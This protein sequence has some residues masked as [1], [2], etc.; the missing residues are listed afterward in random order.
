MANQ[1]I[2]NY[3]GQFFLNNPIIGWSIDSIEEVREVVGEDVYD[4][5]IEDFKRDVYD[6]GIGQILFESGIKFDLGGQTEKSRIIT[7]DNPQGIFDF[8]LAS[9]GLFRVQEFFS[10]DLFKEKRHLFFEYDLPLGVVPVQMINERVVGGEKKYVFTDS[11]G[12]DYY[13]IKQQKGTAAIAQGIQGAKLKFATKTK[14]VYLKFKRSGGKVNYVEIYSMFHY[15]GTYGELGYAL[16]HIPALMVCEYFESIGVKTRFYPTRYV[17]KRD[18]MQL[19]KIDTVSGALLPMY[20]EAEQNGLTTRV[21]NDWVIFQPILAKE[22]GQEVDYLRCLGT[23]PNSPARIY[24][25]VAEMA[26]ERDMLDAYTPYGAPSTEAINYREAF[27]RFKNKS[28]IYVEQGLFNGKEVT[29][30]CQIYHISASLN[31]SGGEILN[32]FTGFAQVYREE[33]NQPRINGEVQLV[34]WL[35][36]NSVCAK[37]AMEFWIRIM[38]FKMRDY[39]ALLVTKEPIK[40]M[41]KIAKN[42]QDEVDN[43]CNFYKTFKFNDAYEFAFTTLF[44]NKTLKTILLQEKMNFVIGQEFTIENPDVQNQISDRGSYY[45][46]GDVKLTEKRLF[47]PKIRAKQYIEALINEAT[48]FA[49]G[50]YF[51]TPPE[52]VERLDNLVER[53]LDELQKADLD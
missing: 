47:I 32:R 4:G 37:K 11:D 30:E 44:L 38:A 25:A 41:K 22:Y 18:N 50:A 19:R 2:N 17:R 40:E 49:E 5:Q 35:I 7:T 12:K 13:C 53:L 14:K 28:Q 20:Q 15:Q 52:Q 23:A 51:P 34:S 1:N 43:L 27:E 31:E 21:R 33:K 29:P 24:E 42:I 8:S 46:L 45:G 26:Q 39:I 9:K 36:S 3:F 10:P 48:I 6:K 16:R